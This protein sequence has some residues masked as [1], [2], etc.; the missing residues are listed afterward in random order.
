M[1][2]IKTHDVSV[3]GRVAGITRDWTGTPGRVG[4]RGHAN[5]AVQNG[6]TATQNTCQHAFNTKR[7]TES[8]HLSYS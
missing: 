8:I 5:V 1:S 6:G 4:T 7:V 3:S 2:G